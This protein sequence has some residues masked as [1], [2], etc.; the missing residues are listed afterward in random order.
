MKKL[1]DALYEDEEDKC[2]CEG[3]FHCPKCGCDKNCEC[4]PM[5]NFTEEAEEQLRK[6]Y[7]VD[8]FADVIARYIYGIHHYGL[9]FE[10]EEKVQDMVRKGIKKF[11]PYFME[12]NTTQLIKRDK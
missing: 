9:S 6:N 3:T 1:Q 7:T 12:C 4:Q 5:K 8:E 11:L 10:D 2:Y